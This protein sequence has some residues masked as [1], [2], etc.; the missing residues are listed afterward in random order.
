MKDKMKIFK[1]LKIIFRVTLI[2]KINKLD[3]VEIYFNNN[4]N[5]RKHKKNIL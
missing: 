1:Y 3:K 5:M 2:L 4:K